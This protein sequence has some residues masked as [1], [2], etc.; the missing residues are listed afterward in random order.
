ML[1]ARDRLPLAVELGAF[2]SDV[3]RLDHVTLLIV[4]AMAKANLSR[5]PEE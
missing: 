3:D 1:F 4:D 2:L 5:M